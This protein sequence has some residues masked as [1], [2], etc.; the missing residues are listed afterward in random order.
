MAELLDAESVRSA[1]AVLDGWEGT[2]DAIV[3]T[4]G[5]RSFPVAIKVVDP[6]TIVETQSKGPKALWVYTMRVSDDGKGMTT[7]MIDNSAVNGVPARGTIIQAR[8]KDAPTGAHLVS[9]TWHATKYEGYS[10]SA[11]SLTLKLEGEKLTFTQPTGQFYAAMLGG[12]AAPAAS[13]Y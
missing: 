1:V 8:T 9:G 4:V 6:R 11:L 12:P 13:R 2:P 5:L 3:R 10:D 7:E